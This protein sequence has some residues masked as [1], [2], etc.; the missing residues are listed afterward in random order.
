MLKNQRGFTL[1][2]LLIVIVIIGI[3]AGVLIAIINPAQ[4][5]NRARD[6]G[7]Q[8][9][10]NKVGLAVEGF[11]SA[12]G[13]A[14]NDVELL[15]SLQNAADVG[16]SCAGGSSETPHVC[17]FTVTGNDL[18][19]DDGS[20]SACA[21]TGWSGTGSTACAYHYYG[22]PV[23][24]TDETHFRL[25]ARSF[26]IANTVFLYDNKIG[27]IVECPAAS[28]ADADVADATDGDPCN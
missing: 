4:Q 26:G 21:A 1:I 5:Q 18:K 3:L 2:E 6:A 27:D 16:T 19:V 24:G 9:T 17:N 7:V 28:I 25:V 12:Y 15:G 11:I 13:R 10:I 20:N 8:A 14:P 23:G 22:E